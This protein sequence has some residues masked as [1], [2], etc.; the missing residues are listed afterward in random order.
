MDPF[1]Q[2]ILIT[3]VFGAAALLVFWISMRSDRR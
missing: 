3:F 2:S 1:I